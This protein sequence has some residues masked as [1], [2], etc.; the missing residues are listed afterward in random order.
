MIQRVHNQI[1]NLPTDDQNCHP[2]IDICV[3]YCSEYVL[4]H[5]LSLIS[6]INEGKMTVGKI[7]VGLLIAE[8]WKAYKASQ[9]SSF[10]LK[11]VSISFLCSVLKFYMSNYTITN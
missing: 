4:V 3:I 7:Y 10:G 11:I 9:T 8:N 1:M 6:E 5:I 2:A